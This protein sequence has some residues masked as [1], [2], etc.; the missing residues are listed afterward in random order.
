MAIADKHPLEGT[1]TTMGTL[2]VEAAPDLPAGSTA[3]IPGTEVSARPVPT[4]P[5]VLS[6][7]VYTVVLETVKGMQATRQASVQAGVAATL[8]FAPADLP[9]QTVA[10]PSNGNLLVQAPD[11]DEPLA[12]AAG[13]AVAVSGRPLKLPAGSWE[14]RISGVSSGTITRS[15]TVLPGQTTSLV[16]SSAD[17]DGAD[18]STT[19]SP[20][21]TVL[22]LGAT[23]AV[24]VDGVPR[25]YAARTEAV[26]QKQGQGLYR[27]AVGGIAPGVHQVQA[28]Y[29][30]GA[31]ET[32]TVPVT[33]G[34]TA[35]VEFSML[36]PI[37]DTTRPGIEV[38]NVPEEISRIWIVGPLDDADT[39]SRTTVLASAAGRAG[40]SAATDLVPGNYEIRHQAGIQ[41]W[42]GGRFTIHM[43][44]TTRLDHAALAWRL[45]YCGP[46]EPG[47]AARAGL[48]MTHGCSGDVVTGAGGLFHDLVLD[49]LGNLVAVRRT[50][51]GLP[52]QV[53]AAAALA[54]TAA[55]G[56]A[57]WAVAGLVR[58]AG[59]PAR[60]T[61]RHGTGLM[62]GTARKLRRRGAP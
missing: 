53:L 10:E 20:G 57:A 56:A 32:R 44:G 46:I 4:G 24:G 28:T 16:L 26:A 59:R 33:P 52:W 29:Q 55:V 23:V 54:G 30:T 9:L 2:S 42:S 22:S 40:T 11:L 13:T 19:P 31:I 49:A 51:E 58:R 36:G 8:R 14:V 37:D 1:P 34:R 47:S 15:V 6:P 25:G 35:Y 60:E 27:L 50:D 7:G 62:A 41:S 12:V 18:P 38:V 17:F 61:S 48:A 5:V 45:V 39:L 43:G 3:T 21:L